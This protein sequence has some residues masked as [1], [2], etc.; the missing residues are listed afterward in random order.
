VA[1]NVLDYWARLER[2]K[3]LV[4]EADRARL[5]SQAQNGQK[6]GNC[7]SG[8]LIWLGRR[9]VVWGRRL[10]ERYGAE[11]QPLRSAP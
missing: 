8:V 5:V 2:Y 7:L 4:R 6:R 9:L 11:P 3:D 10:E 1:A